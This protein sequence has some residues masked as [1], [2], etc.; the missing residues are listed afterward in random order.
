SK[1]PLYRYFVIENP[2]DTLVTE[3]LKWKFPE[4]DIAISNGFRFC[5]PLVTQDGQGL[6]QIPLS[7]LYD[8]LPVDS[9]IKTGEVTGKQLRTW[10]EKEL[11]NVFATE[12]SKRVGGWLVKFKGMKIKFYVNRELGSRLQSVTIGGKMLQDDKTYTI[13]ACEREGDPD[14][15]LCRLEDVK[16]ARQTGVSL[17]DAV[18]DY[19]AVNSP[20]NPVPRGDAVALD[21]PPT[22][23]TQ[24]NGVPYE[25]R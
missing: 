21:V 14:N 17:H 2:I 25:F 13:L 1:T 8:M 3:A 5:P 12:A 9:A 22:L 11:N 10:L 15:K 24:V 20:V 4:I 16:A 6:I 23:L 7:Y 19:L 18:I